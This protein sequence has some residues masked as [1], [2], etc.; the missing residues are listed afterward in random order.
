[1]PDNQVQAYLLEYFCAKGF[2][3]SSFALPLH[4]FLKNEALF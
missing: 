2:A 1:M 4:G 3:N